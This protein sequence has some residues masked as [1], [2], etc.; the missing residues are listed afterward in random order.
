MKC[1][2]HHFSNSAWLIISLTKNKYKVI[3][4]WASLIRGRN[5]LTVMASSK[6]VANLEFVHK[7]ICS[8]N[9]MVPFRVKYIFN[10]VFDIFGAPCQLI[11]KLETINKQKTI[12][13]WLI[14]SLIN[15]AHLKCEK[16]VKWWA[17][18]CSILI[19]EPEFF[20]IHSIF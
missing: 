7:K 5:P 1:L 12:N 17:S 18:L 11:R 15:L 6:M 10:T 20:V 9:F 14:I 3:E 4:T 8:L 2:A 13:Y 16:L 19:F